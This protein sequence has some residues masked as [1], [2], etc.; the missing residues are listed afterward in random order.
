MSQYKKEPEI[1]KIP[2]PKNDGTF[3]IFTE[4]TPR[5]KEILDDYLKCR[6]IYKASEVNVSK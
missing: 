3:V 4:P 2:H 5:Q 1:V 6:K